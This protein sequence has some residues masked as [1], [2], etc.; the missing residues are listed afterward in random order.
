MF[1]KRRRIPVLRLAWRNTRRNT[2]RTLL[3]IVAVTIAVTAITFMFAYITGIL[4]NFVD[5]YARTESGHVRIRKD[6]YTERERLMPVY[7]KVDGVTE[8]LSRIREHP[9]VEEAVPRIRSSVL[10]DGAGSNRPGLLLGLD[11]DR[12]GE[13][14]NPLGMA[15]NGNPPHPGSPEVMIGTEFADKLSIEIGD[16]ITVL[17]Q[18]AYRSLGG[19]RLV[20]TDFAFSG[21]SFLDNSMLVVPIDQAQLL[22]DMP[23]AATEILVFSHDVEL[24]ESLATELENELEPI[25]DGDIE[26]L[27]WL[28]QGQ[29][30]RTMQMMRPLLGVVMGLMLLMA[31]LIIVNTMLMTVMERTQELG[32]QAALGMRRT[33]IVYLIVSEGLVIGLLGGVI[34]A[35]LGSGIGIWLE[36]S[37]ID[38]TAAARG[39]DL[40]FQGIVYPDWTLSYAVIGMFLGMLAAGVAALYPALRAIKM[41]PAEALRQ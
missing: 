19:L 32:M 22:A 38:F 18:T 14:L 12:E 4:G 8:L 28:D 2:R 5:S 11:I 25:V 26:V 6:G 40:P 29:L 31:G 41:A 23:D 24:A 21:I 37:G 15:V 35:I 39:I 34:G 33:D 17:G 20:V 7:L 13:Y 1:S 3:T 9:D 16:T 27:S 30:M 10:V 36:H